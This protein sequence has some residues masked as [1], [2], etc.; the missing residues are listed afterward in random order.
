M[1]NA[2]TEN[3]VRQMQKFGLDFMLSMISPGDPSDAA[4]AIIKGNV[5]S[6]CHTKRRMGM[7]TAHS[8]FFWYDDYLGT[9]H[10]L[11]PGEGRQISRG[12]TV[13]KVTAPRKF[14]K[15]K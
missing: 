15:N 1:L 12:N 11:S 7:Y 14:G 4:L 8:S 2:G 6:C 3:T 5:L 13:K 9:I 10:K